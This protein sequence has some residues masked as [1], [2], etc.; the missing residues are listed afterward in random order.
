MVRLTNPATGVVV[1]VP[2]SLVERLGGAWVP[3]GA[4]EAPARK[5]AARKQ[6]ARKNATK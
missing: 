3:A 4:V 6:T 2:E 5:P 1:V